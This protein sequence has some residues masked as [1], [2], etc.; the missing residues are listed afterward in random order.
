MIKNLRRNLK[1]KNE[2][3]L[4]KVNTNE[5]IRLTIMV[6][7][8]AF[9]SGVFFLNFSTIDEFIKAFLWDYRSAF[10]RDY[11][12]RD[13]FFKLYDHLPNEEEFKLFSETRPP[14]Q[15]SKELGAVIAFTFFIFPPL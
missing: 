5:H 7:F 2:T 13:T 10:D 1:P 3:V 6:G 12:I 4:I 14:R 11:F 9:T 15:Y 8:L